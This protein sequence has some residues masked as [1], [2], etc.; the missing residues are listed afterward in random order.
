MGDVAVKYSDYGISDSQWSKLSPRRVQE[1]CQTPQG[2]AQIGRLLQRNIAPKDINE[3]FENLA[4]QGLSVEKEE[5]STEITPE[6]T[7]EEVAAKQK[8]KLEQL[9]TDALKI[10]PEM[11][12]DKDLR[13]LNKS[14]WEH[15][16]LERYKQNT[17]EARRDIVQVMYHKE[18]REMKQTLQGMMRDTKAEKML[19]SKYLA[20]GFATEEEKERYE[21]RKAELRKLYMEE[22]RAKYDEQIKGLQEQLSKL[23]ENDTEGRAAI[24][25]QIADVR[26]QRER[27]CDKAALDAYN[28]IRPP[29]EKVQ[30]KD[31]VQEGE[32]L[33]TEQ[34]EAILDLKALDA[35]DITE[36]KIEEMAISAVSEHKFNKGVA[37]VTKMREE[38]AKIKEENITD[39]VKR[40][41][42]KAI[43][44]DRAY[45]EQIS[46]LLQEAETDESL[47]LRQE[48]AEA[49]LA[50]RLE[51]T[52]LRKA[53]KTEEADALEK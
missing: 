8:D 40:I 7:P 5:T 22:P 20:E 15:Y 39:E 18:V 46:T 30:E 34:I 3:Y 50:T 29:H 13:E 53:G 2:A 52:K 36:G 10:T 43:M 19:K 49:N 42:G 11:M 28:S 9:R 35:F 48:A 33:S 32:H 12:D 47:K 17:D 51:I 45:D 26:E 6:D 14:Q 23:D 44:A 16:F 37:D 24:E 31:W 4:V 1:L 21:A 41:Q 25:K 27:A 38:I